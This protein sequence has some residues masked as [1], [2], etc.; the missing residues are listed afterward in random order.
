MAANEG[1][2]TLVR[3]RP[4]VFLGRRGGG[5]RPAIGAGSGEWSGSVKPRRVR[6]SCSRSASRLG[7]MTRSALES[8]S[9]PTTELWGNADR[10]MVATLPVLRAMAPS[11]GS[12]SKQPGSAGELYGRA[13]R[14]RAPSKHIPTALGLM[15]IDQRSKAENEIRMAWRTSEMARRR[16][17]AGLQGFARKAGSSDIIH[18]G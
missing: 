6:S 18:Y 15:L 1:P 11:G 14:A 13:V 5:G 17:L 4:L 3:I 9:T 12:K 2:S 10:D 16:Y 8:W 7:E